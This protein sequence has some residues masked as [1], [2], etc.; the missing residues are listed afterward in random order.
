[1]LEG[2]SRVGV[3]LL[4]TGKRR[5]GMTGSDW[6]SLTVE[7]DKSATALARDTFGCGQVYH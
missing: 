6:G 2:E 7:F 4:I 3:H 1:M 5:S